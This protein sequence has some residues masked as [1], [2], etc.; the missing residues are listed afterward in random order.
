[1]KEIAQRT[2]STYYRPAQKTPPRSRTYMPD[3]YK[4]SSPRNTREMP[5]S[6][7]RLFLGKKFQ[8]INYLIIN[9]Q[10]FGGGFFRKNNLDLRYFI[11]IFVTYKWI[12][13]EM[14]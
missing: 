1:M 8:F 11:L 12:F 4:S 13:S 10:F 2:S 5:D 3:G 6:A 9:T 7:V 14:G